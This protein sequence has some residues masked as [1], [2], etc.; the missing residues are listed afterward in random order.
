MADPTINSQTSL[1][2]L[3]QAYGNE[4]LKT[5]IPRN[6]DIRDAHM[7]KQDIFSFSPEAKSAYAYNKLIDEVF[8]EQQEK[9]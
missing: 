3:R 6:T 4:V 9:N 2:I 8:Y 1:K 5:I 7:A